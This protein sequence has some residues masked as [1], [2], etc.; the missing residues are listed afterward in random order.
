[1]T[2]ARRRAGPSSGTSDAEPLRLLLL[3]RSL[4]AGGAE[5]QLV[6]LAGGL[7]GSR[8][9]ITVA[10]LY[11]RGP[12]RDDLARLAGVRLA[13]LGKS[14]RWDMAGPLLRLVRLIRAARIQVV[15]GSLD[16]ANL[17]AL[18]G[19]RLGGAKVVFGVRSAF[20]D[21]TRYARS[22]ERVWRLAAFASRAADRV[23][24][25]SFAGRDYAL[26][27]GFSRRNAVVVPNGIDV[28]RFRP[29]REG[30]RRVR[31]EW[32]VP[33]EAPLVGL[34]GRLDPMKDHE[35]FLDAA[36]LVR[37]ESP[38][39]R[40][41]CVGEGPGAFAAGLRARAAQRGLEEALVWAGAREDMPAVYGALDVLALSSRGEA[42]PNVVGEAMACGV[43]CV[44][45]D[46]GD[47]A[48]IVG[49]EGVVVPPQDPPALAAGLR[50][51]LAEPPGERAARSARCRARIVS[52]FP[53]S[54][55]AAATGRELARV[56]RN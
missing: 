26:S 27:R 33:P 52:E 42:F 14:G 56:V 29:D 54:A 10:V 51:L 22:E 28:A 36:A 6:E 32:G 35:A 50:L 25:N 55:L 2:R 43:P 20:M 21:F 13:S 18:A 44:V 49:G 8:F 39:V 46:V 38:G 17:Y 4:E 53:R 47:A 12:L 48:R 37:R 16:I 7:D 5:R 1:M 30:G 15:Y 19:G 41:V 9:A 45:T 34:V 24:Y 11:D 31:G 40:F 3:A 23:I